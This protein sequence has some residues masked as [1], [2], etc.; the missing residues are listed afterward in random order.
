MDK[1]VFYITVDTFIGNLNVYFSIFALRLTFFFLIF[2]KTESEELATYHNMSKC[3]LYVCRPLIY[4]SGGEGS[5]VFNKFFIKPR[6]KLVNDGSKDVN[7]KAHLFWGP[8]S[9][10]NTLSNYF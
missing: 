9:S 6:G 4:F 10:D 3:I 5:K 8:V 2:F 7:L 1:I